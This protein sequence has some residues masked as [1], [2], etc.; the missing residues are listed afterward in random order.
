MRTKEEV[1][2]QLLKTVIAWAECLLVGEVN[3][4]APSTPLHLVP[5][6]GRLPVSPFRSCRPDP[7][8]PARVHVVCRIRIASSTRESR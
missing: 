1:Y 4:A 7:A 8:D 6:R 3:I 5:P 2:V